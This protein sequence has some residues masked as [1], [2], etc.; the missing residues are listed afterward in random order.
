VVTL[1]DYRN[2]DFG[3]KYGALIKEL[4]LL[5]RAVFVLDERDNLVHVEYVKEV[6]EHPNYDAALQAGRKAAGA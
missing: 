5:A 6:A 2:A 4:H 1:S 3:N